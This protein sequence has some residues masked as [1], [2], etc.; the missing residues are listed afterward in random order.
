[1]T[2]DQ[3]VLPRQNIKILAAF[4]LI[5]VDQTPM[6]QTVT[7]APSAIEQAVEK[8]L[9]THPEL[10]RDA[11]N[12]LQR[13]ETADIAKQEATTLAE[14]TKEIYS[15]TGSIVLGNPTGDVTL[16]EFI[17]Y[18]CG[19]CKKMAPGIEQLIQRD[20]QLRVL[21]K[22]LPVLG[23]ESIA[24]AQLMLSVE[25]GPTVAQVHQT[26]ITNQDLDAASLSLIEQ[27]YQLKPVNKIL[28]NRGLGEVRVLSEKLGIQGTPVLIIGDTIFRG[29]VET[30]QLEEAI[31]MARNTLLTRS[32]AKS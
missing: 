13:R 10:V 23:P 9:K 15:E 17:D 7:T 8:V 22:Q 19:Y 4:I 27:K 24:A 3:R 18:H 14:S 29:A 1:M 28:A 11:L 30:A 31:Q 20:S 16:V 12:E 26:L 32:K 25:S 5:L 21:V 2:Y 6:A